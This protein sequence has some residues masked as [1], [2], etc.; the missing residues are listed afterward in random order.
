M[1]CGQWFW[2]KLGSFVSALLS[3]DRG[4]FDHSATAI[5]VGW[6]LCLFCSKIYP[7]NLLPATGYIRGLILLFEA[8]KEKQSRFELKANQVTGRDG[9]PRKESEQKSPTVKTVI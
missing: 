9:A 3:L 4:A 6:Y 5:H 7:D 2:C 1:R 8:V